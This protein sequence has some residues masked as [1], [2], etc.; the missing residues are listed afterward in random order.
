MGCMQ[1]SVHLMHRYQKNLQSKTVLSSEAAVT[2]LF[3]GQIATLLLCFAKHTYVR[4]RICGCA[5]LFFLF[6]PLNFAKKIRVKKIQRFCTKNE[7]HCVPNMIYLFVIFF[8]FL[9]QFLYLNMSL[10]IYS[11]I[12]HRQ[13]SHKNLDE[14]LFNQ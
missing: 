14:R 5:R 8:F 13:S 9:S 3:V 11:L 10:V 7:L 6:I 12:S 4:F 1:Y 2:H